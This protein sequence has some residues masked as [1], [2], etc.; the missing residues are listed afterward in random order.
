MTKRCSAVATT[1]HT[2]T[3]IKVLNA[4]PHSHPP[5]SDNNDDESDV[6]DDLNEEDSVDDATSAEESDLNESDY[7][8]QY[9]LRQAMTGQV[10]PFYLPSSV[11]TERAKRN[12]IL[13]GR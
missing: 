4:R 5:L 3:K 8:A 1:S 7:Y 12:A 9:Y 13:K 2:G 11:I 10:E 6:D